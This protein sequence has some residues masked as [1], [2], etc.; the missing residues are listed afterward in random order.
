MA[1]LSITSGWRR[2]RATL[3]AIWRSPSLEPSASIRGVSI[4][5][6]SLGSEV[7]LAWCTLNRRDRNAA[8]LDERFHPDRGSSLSP[9]H[10]R[11]PTAIQSQA[12]TALRPSGLQAALPR[13]VL[14]PKAQTLS[15]HRNA[16]R[17]ARYELPGHDPARRH[18]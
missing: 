2:A 1:A 11:D 16:L 10:G 15:P 4:L 14:L 3:G 9:L 12:P 17:Q 6:K 5:V 13:R 7:I 8:Q 18:C